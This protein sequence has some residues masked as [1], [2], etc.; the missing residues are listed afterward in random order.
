MGIEVQSFLTAL[1]LTP[2]VFQRLH[3]Q[4]PIQRRPGGGPRVWISILE[5]KRS[6]HHLYVNY[7][8]QDQEMVM[9]ILQLSHGAHIPRR[10][11]PS[12]LLR[13]GK[14]FVVKT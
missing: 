1:T 9:M 12:M 4:R 8:C 10:L 3:H 6:F 13:Q 7:V 11:Y 2:K 5:R 14:Y